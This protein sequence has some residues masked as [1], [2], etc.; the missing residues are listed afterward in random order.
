MRVSVAWMQLANLKIK[1]IT[2]E[3]HTRTHN[4]NLNTIKKH[5]KKQNKM[6]T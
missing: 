6:K 2:K 4:N 5:I 1:E 3:K